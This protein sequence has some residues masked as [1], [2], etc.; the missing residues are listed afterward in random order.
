MESTSSQES[1][2]Q[3]LAAV[4]GVVGSMVFA[5]SGA[6]VAASFPPV[7][8]PT[9]L[10]QLASQLTSDTYFQE[11]LASEQ[12]ALDLRYADGRVLIRSMRGAWLLVLSTAQANSQL[13]S[14][15]MTQA[16]RRLRAPAPARTGTGAPPPA[17]ASSALDRL[18]AIANTELGAHAGQALEIL[19]AAGPKPKDLARAAA[20]IEKMTRLFIDKRKAEE[21]AQMMRDVLHA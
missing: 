16:V 8:D 7:F 10:Q 12:G 13:L 6:V 20:D 4:P 14:M 5:S 21:I 1:A 19:A 3:Q 9:G 15:S 2:L 17:R 18:R 11:W